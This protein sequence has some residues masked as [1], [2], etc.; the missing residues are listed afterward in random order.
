MIKTK[1]RQ[2]GF[3]LIE[4]LI[5]VAITGILSSVFVTFG[6]MIN[7]FRVGYISQRLYTAITMAKSEAI[8]RKKNVTLCPSSS[9]SQC[10]AQTN[11]N[12]GWL[13]FY[14]DNGNAQVDGSDQLIRVYNAVPDDVS[15]LWSGPSRGF[16]FNGRG[17][18]NLT[19]Q[20]N[21]TICLSGIT[22][23][24]A[25]QVN[26]YGKYQGDRIKSIAGHN[27]C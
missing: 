20:Y 13:V 7:D 17:Q 18:T 15:I 23:S 22:N 12:N 4:L 26:V 9:G 27:N 19:R 21:F 11:W 24:P 25:Q 16:S 8:K 6:K 3:T 10:Y 14:D 5:I 2:S 1:I